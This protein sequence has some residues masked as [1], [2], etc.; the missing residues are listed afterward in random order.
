MWDRPLVSVPQRLH[1]WSNMLFSDHGVFRLFYLNEHRL[2]DE[3]A[4][5]AQPAP[6]DI[7]RLAR[8]GFRTIINLRGG[9]EHGAWPLQREACEVNRLELRE[10]TLR[11]REAPDREL[12]LALPKFLDSIA[13]PALAH[14]KS[15]A[16]RVGLFS[17]LYVL[18]RLGGSAAEARRQLSFRFGHA[19]FAKTGVL[20]AFIDAYERDGESKGLAFMDWVRDV[21]DPA[22]LSAEFHENFWASLLIDRIL[23]RE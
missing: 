10:F 8:Q 17:A 12:L 18:I 14:C 11:S 3:F 7:A 21:Y 5:S 16:D 22:A 19:R 4:R 23:K 13:Y 6:H 9:R 20:D 2:T 15:G 1:A